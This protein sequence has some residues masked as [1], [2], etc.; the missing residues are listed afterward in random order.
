MPD[1]KARRVIWVP[2]IHAQE[3][4]GSLRDSVRRVAIRRSGRQSWE[5]QVRKVE[6]R[7]RDTRDRIDALD[8]DY[9][10][11]RLYQDGLPVCGE[12]E[13]IVRDLAQA[14]SPNHRI[15]LEL[16]GRGG[17]LMG[18]E[19]PALLLEEYELARRVMAALESPH[20]GTPP[21]Q[22]T[23]RDLLER[24]DRAVAERIAATLQPG[25]TGLIFLGMLHSL[26]GR[27]PDD[28]E[29]VLLDDAAPARPAPRAP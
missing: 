25:E 28:V 23:S 10:R 4:L 3:D 18:T 11:L 15:L 13:R 19:P 1:S 29:L 17:R 12:E 9:G 6:Q 20:R 21:S 16:M 14:G 2:I 27:F 8:L 22:E 24:R 7:W 26:A 5:E